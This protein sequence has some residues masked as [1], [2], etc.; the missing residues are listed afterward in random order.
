ML[1][2]FGGGRGVGRDRSFVRRSYNIAPVFTS[3][4]VPGRAGRTT[5]PPFSR[6]YSWTGRGCSREM[7][8]SSK[9]GGV[10]KYKRE[11][12]RE[13]ERILFALIHCRRVAMVAGGSL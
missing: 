10:V 3:A 6:N 13:R 7:A 8:L 9:G 5:G 4:V 1:F 11:R 12:E 2:F